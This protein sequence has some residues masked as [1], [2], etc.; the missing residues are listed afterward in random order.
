V[1]AAPAPKQETTL[2]IL[3]DA[4]RL[5]DAQRQR[6]NA[7]PRPAQDKTRLY[8][9]MDEAADRLGI[10]GPRL[11][12]PQPVA[13]PVLKGVD[14]ARMTRERNL[15][16]LRNRIAIDAIAQAARDAAGPVRDLTQQQVLD[17][18]GAAMGMPGYK[19]VDAAPCI[20]RRAL[21]GNPVVVLSVWRDAR[22]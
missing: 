15:T 11:S 14:K 8:A 22:A 19:H 3:Q 16:R 5:A 12:K 18:L 17:N 10:K 9:L 6:A 13:Q 4:G 1:K 7:Q 21:R 20:S 2:E